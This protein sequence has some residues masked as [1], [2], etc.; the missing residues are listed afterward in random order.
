MIRKLLMFRLG[1]EIPN[2]AVFIRSQTR[3]CDDQDDHTGLM[4][5]IYETVYIYE[6]TMNQDGEEKK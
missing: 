4:P 1:E 6:V 2:G 3:A 5:L